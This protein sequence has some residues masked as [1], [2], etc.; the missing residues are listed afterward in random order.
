MAVGL[1]GEAAKLWQKCFSQRSSNVSDLDEVEVQAGEAGTDFC[2]HRLEHFSRELVDDI[3]A[4]LDQRPDSVRSKC[5][6]SNKVF[7]ER[8][9]R[10]YGLRGES[11]GV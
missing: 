8:G 2:E 11:T 9:V 4:A 5:G 3:S 10:E 7:T 6:V 1:G